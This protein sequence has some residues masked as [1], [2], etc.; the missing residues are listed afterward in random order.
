MKLSS[1]GFNQPGEEEG[2][3]SFFDSFVLC[4]LLC[5]MFCPVPHFF[6]V[7]CLDLYYVFFVLVVLFVFAWVW[8]ERTGIH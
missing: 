6:L 3:G 7:S 8:K 4:K 2:S 5:M 1:S